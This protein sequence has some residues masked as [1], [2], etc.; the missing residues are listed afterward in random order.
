MTFR[1]SLAVPAL[2]VATLAIAAAAAQL[3][4]ARDAA[5]YCHRDAVAYADACEYSAAHPILTSLVWR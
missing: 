3:F 5:D 1:R 4:I 2:Y